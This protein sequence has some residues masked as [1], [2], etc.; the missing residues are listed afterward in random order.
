MHVVVGGASGFLGRH[1]IGALR[2]QG[3]TTT[4]LVRRVPASDDESQ[5]DPG[6]GRLDAAVIERADVVVNLAGSPTIGNPHSKRWASNLRES[7]V[8]TTRTLADAIA[9]SERRPAFLAGNAVA[10]YGDHGDARVTEAGD[11][12]GHTLM[13]EV[14]R[15]WEAAAQPAIAA[16]AR[17]CVLRTAPV[18]DHD[19]QPLRLLSRVYRLGLGGKVGNGRQ[20]FPMVSLRDWVG[21]V[22]HLAEHPEASGPFNL[23]CPRT[24]T[25]AEFTRALARAV[26]R[27]AFVPVPSVAVSVGAGPL[28]PELLGSANLVPQALVDAGYDF[29][30]HD[31][32]DV[33]AAGL[34]GKR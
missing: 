31:V 12:R 15:E 6:A 20:Y 1:L 5:W 7:R 11:S 26:G 4:S 2:A 23:C 17:V 18:M 13:T 27:P 9:A 33:V 21:G 29:L 16:G 22:V 10:I 34:A 25:N 24:P 30:D 8:T 14:T 3:H 19:A 28:S 32:T